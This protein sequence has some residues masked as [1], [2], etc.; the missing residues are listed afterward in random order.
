M[1]F[2]AL[3]LWRAGCCGFRPR[4]PGRRHVIA[5]SP[6]VAADLK[7]LGL[8]R[9]THV[10]ANGL[11]VGTYA[12]AAQDGRLLDA[13]A[14]LPLAPPSCLRV[15]LVATY[16]RWKGQAVFLDAAAELAKTCPGLP[17]RFYVIGGPIY[18]T[19]GSQYTKD[20]LLQHAGCLGIADRV[21]FIGFQSDVVP[22]YRALDV[23]VHAS[24]APEPFGLTIIEA[25]AC[26]KPVIATLGG[27][28]AD[29][30]EPGRD[31]LGIAP[32]NSSLLAGT[33][34]SLLEDSLLR[35]SLGAEAR[36]TVCRRFNQD[37]I[38]TQV[39]DLYFRLTAL[40]IETLAPKESAPALSAK[41]L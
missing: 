25:M 20:E 5:I 7:V 15:G 39:L 18:R 26:G 9:R 6:A 23:V 16:A 2:S 24:T 34:R 33:M 21:G 36:R 1:I 13:L 28:V 29:I 17:V 10:I 11:D 41:P 35:A 8:E 37:R 27:G 32:A 40:S 22:I 4:Q 19:R 30:I 12:P 14:G 3:V 31:A 38:G